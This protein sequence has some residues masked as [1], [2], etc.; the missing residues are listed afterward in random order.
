MTAL[1]IHSKLSPHEP[2]SR[3]DFTAAVLELVIGKLC[4]LYGEPRMFRVNLK[5]DRVYDYGSL[6]GRLIC[7]TN[8][9]EENLYNP[10]CIELYGADECN[11]HSFENK[12]WVCAE[13]SQ[14]AKCW[15]PAVIYNQ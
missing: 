6:C 4:I 9:N 3:S 13:H 10:L 7:L 14:A 11:V 12:G 1:T 15:L 2:H 5:C 8:G